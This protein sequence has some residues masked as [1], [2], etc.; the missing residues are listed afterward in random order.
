MLL[1]VYAGNA[2]IC[3]HY[4]K[5]IIL[6]ITRKFDI[7]NEEIELPKLYLNGKLEKFQLS[8]SKIAWSLTSNSHVQGT[9]ATVQ[10]LLAGDSI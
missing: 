2:L 1:V 6:I 7:E 5:V 8:N 9:V 3:S 10:C 4:S